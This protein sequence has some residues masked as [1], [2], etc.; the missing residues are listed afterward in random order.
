MIE[1]GSYSE[2][3]SSSS[4]NEHHQYYDFSDPDAMAHTLQNVL[5][6]D[7]PDKKVME[8]S[9]LTEGETRGTIG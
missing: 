7:D 5:V 6:L 8:V 1:N 3:D 4:S 9:Y 2:I